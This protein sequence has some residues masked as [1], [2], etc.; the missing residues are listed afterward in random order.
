MPITRCCEPSTLRGVDELTEHALS[1]LILDGV[2]GAGIVFGTEAAAIPAAQLAEAGADL[3][4]SSASAAVGVLMTN[5]RP[6]VELLLG[7]IAVGAVL[8]SLPLPSRGADLKA[9]GD[10]LRAS[11][12]AHEVKEIV[13]RDDIAE[14]LDGLGLPTRPHT[15]LRHD[16]PVAAPTGSGFQLVQFSSGST[17]RPKPV[18]LADHVIGAN[19]AGI[20]DVLDPRPGDCAVSW[21]PLSHDMGLIGMLLTSISAASPA[22][23]GQGTIVLL[24]PTEFLRRPAQ[25]LEAL[26]RWG[27]TFTAAPDFGLRMAAQHPPSSLLDLSRLRVAIVGGE[28]VRA[29]TLVTFTETYRAM[30]LA[31]RALCPAYGLAEATLA[32]TLTGPEEM[33]RRRTVDAEALVCERVAAATPGGATAILVASGPPLPHHDVDCG[34]DPDIVGPVSVRGPS[35]GIDGTTGQS[36]ADLHSW[37]QTGDVGFLDDGW[38]YVCGRA[39]DYL[40]THGRQVYAP[41]VEAAVGGVDGVRSGRVTAVALPTGHWSLV[42]EEASSYPLTSREQTN[43]RRAIRL[44]VTSVATAQPDNVVLVRRGTLPLT[45]SGKL[46]RNEVRS[47]LVRG[48]LVEDGGSGSRG[49]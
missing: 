30:G 48:D 12:E 15:E 29:D 35:I 40:V 13:A 23:V 19:V 4:G 16:Q 37:Y 6:T 3:F 49:T 46:R 20:L 32:V 27:G 45:A 8:V 18:V 22:R 36:F 7:A 14:L 11:C 38:L 21:L 44:A 24:E 2:D 47:R 9:Y 5:D 25:W 1:K 43:L 34:P 33:W 39:D 31:S 26:D 10:L 42:A 41:A 28:I 17:H